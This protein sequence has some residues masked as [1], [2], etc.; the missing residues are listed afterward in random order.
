[1]V[2]KPS[3]MTT[4]GYLT[5]ITVLFL[6][7]LGVAL[8]FFFR[9]SSRRRGSKSHHDPGPITFEP[10]A[11]SSADDEPEQV[12]PHSLREIETIDDEPQEV[13]VKVGS[14]DDSSSSD[15]SPTADRGREY[16]D[17]LQDAAAGLAELMRSSE[18]E[19]TEKEVAEE[20][21]A[22]EPAEELAE[23]SEVEEKLVVEVE[24]EE[25]V[26]AERDEPAE[27]DP[28]MEPT[29][30]HSQTVKTVLGEQVADQIDQIDSG[31]DALEELVASIEESLE[32][33]SSLAEDG[34]DLEDDQ[35]SPTGDF[36]EAA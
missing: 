25:V 31:L 23:T 24:K 10:S 18:A 12:E 26:A 9:R 13:T 19:S 8:F 17:D 7:G 21:I 32:A 20:L 33:F 5:L 34:D 2:K 11:I 14:L 1:M 4:G 6:V 3:K 16:F 28:E 36:A 22:Q 15:P 27:Q 30:T 35:S 29:A